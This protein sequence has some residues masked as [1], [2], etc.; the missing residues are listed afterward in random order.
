MASP[1]PWRPGRPGRRHPSSGSRR[2]VWSQEHP[3]PRRASERQRT[4]G[5]RR[6]AWP[7]NAVQSH[8]SGVPEL[9]RAAKRWRVEPGHEAACTPSELCNYG[10]RTV[11]PADTQ[12][13][14]APGGRELVSD[15]SVRSFLVASTAS[16]IGMFLQA[17]AL[18]KQLFDITDSTLALGLLGLV[19]FL[20]AL[21]LL[22]LTGSAADRFDRRRV[23]AIGLSAE[24]LT[25]IA[26]CVYAATD[27]TSGL[28]HLRHRGHVRSGAGV[29]RAVNALAAATPRAR[30]WPA[31]PDRPLLRHVAVRDD[32]RPG[33][34][35][36]PVRRRSD[37]AVPGRGGLL[38]GFG[39]GGDDAEVQ[40]R[41]AAHAF[42]RAADPAPC[43][44]GP[45]LHPPPARPPRCDRARPVRRA[46]RRRGRP[47][48]GDRRGAPGRRQRR[49]RV[50]AR[51]AR[52]RR[53]RRHGG[54]RSEAGSPARRRHPARRGR[55]VRG[56]D[57]GLRSHD[58][59]RRRLPRAAR[60]L[61]ARTR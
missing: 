40:A 12:P 50:V 31:P 28:P 29:R 32:R 57:G 41:P 7:G 35:R 5:C 42:R 27:P 47:P 15:R 38:P 58:E 6:P 52:G 8:R 13:Q 26:F 19:E 16:S 11:E 49:I 59:L 25:S 2:Q 23:A 3:E 36:V 4:S 14:T 34:Q 9:R 56:G 53:R 44:R 24:V 48:A 54:A 21:I 10:R 18:G 39:G 22:P 33:E 45:A 37:G 17:A 60:P 30:R 61:R 1:R 51:G 55:A 46:L 43:A 20:P